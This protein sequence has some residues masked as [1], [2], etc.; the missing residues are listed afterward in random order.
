MQRCA[1]GH[2]ESSR[3]LVR[4][5]VRRPIAA[6][7]RFS[8]VTEIPDEHFTTDGGLDQV[9]D[10]VAAD[11]IRRGILD[12]LSEVELRVA[13]MR[14]GIGGANPKP[15]HEVADELALDPV[16]VQRLENQAQKNSSSQ[17]RRCES[18]SRLRPRALRHTSG[19]RALA[20]RRLPQ[21]RHTSRALRGWLEEH[22]CEAAAAGRPLYRSR[23]SY[24]G[25]AARTL[26]SAT[27]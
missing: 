1:T 23:T 8:V 21:S 2:R 20:W 12:A 11:Q 9:L 6:A 16:D 22:S 25:V 13:T 5:V 15:L 26:L 4:R 24:V 17:S 14:W 7:I 10:N 27:S 3:G 18:R 19:P